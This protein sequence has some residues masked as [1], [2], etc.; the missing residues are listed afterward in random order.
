MSRFG[1]LLVMISLTCQG[2]AAADIEGAEIIDYFGYSGC[3]ALHN[4]SIR[5]VLT[6]HGGRILE[7]SRDGA[8]AIYLD[9]A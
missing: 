4:D 6:T 2:V 8:N 9:P 1:L 5:V 7:Y 3:V